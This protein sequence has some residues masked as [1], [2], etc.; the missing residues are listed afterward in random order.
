[1][2]T[3]ILSCVVFLP[4]LVGVGC[5]GLPRHPED[6]TGASQRAIS[7]FNCGGTNLGG[8]NLGGANLGG[9]NLGGANLGGANLSGANLGGANLGGTNLGGAN[10]GGANLGATNLGGA[11][12]AGLNLAGS[13]LAGTTLGDSNLALVSV[14]P[15]ALAGWDIA[16][17]RLAAGDYSGLLVTGVDQSGGML[18]SGA[19]G[20]YFGVGSTAT[21]RFVLENLAANAPFHLIVARLPW[22]ISHDAG[23]ERVLDVYEVVA[24]GGLSWTVALVTAP[25]ATTLEGVM[26][27]LK[28]IYRY[29]LPVSWPFYIHGG[30]MLLSYTGMMGAAQLVEGGMVSDTNFVLGILSFTSAT[31]NNQSV[32]VDF[33]SGILAA[34][35]HPIIL[36]NVE[37]ERFHAYEGEYI[38]IVRRNEQ[39]FD[40]VSVVLMYDERTLAHTEANVDSV[41][42]AF[43]TADLNWKLYPDQYPRPMPTRCATA[44]VAKNVYPEDYP[45]DL[46]SMKCDSW[47]DFVEQDPSAHYG[48]FRL[49]YDAP[50]WSDIGGD[51]EANHVMYAY[52]KTIQGAQTC[53]ASV[54]CSGD[55]PAGGPWTAVASTFIFRPIS[56]Y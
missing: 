53:D 14:P 2:R 11:N 34:D 24:A 42:D 6:H 50:T 55:I 30:G 22:G 33:S 21:A 48:Q 1:M 25:P 4:A 46:I 16:G 15:G 13:D 20:A 18:A 43:F 56:D 32:M 52:P 49:S 9:A 10:L 26:G 27:F 37:F 19:P 7:G 45:E 36:G 39:G 12:L 44:H 51:V 31:T 5:T 40:E 35:G 41:Y 47:V 29:N 54:G 8:A 23:G 17:T 3:A 38:P 28:A